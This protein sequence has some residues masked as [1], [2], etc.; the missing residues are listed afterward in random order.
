MCNVG[1][2]RKCYL[3]SIEKGWG[4]V[5]NNCYPYFISI[6]LPYPRFTVNR[7]ISKFVFFFEVTG[8]YFRFFIKFNKMRE[9]GTLSFSLLWL[10]LRFETALSTRL[11]LVILSLI[12]YVKN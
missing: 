5:I 1:G 2:K 10:A 12:L 3:L 7:I 9:S 11:H 6:F 4:A 8:I